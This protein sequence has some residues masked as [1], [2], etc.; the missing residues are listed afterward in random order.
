MSN[1]LLPLVRFC[2][3]AILNMLPTSF[4]SVHEVSAFLSPIVGEKGQSRPPQLVAS[5]NSILWVAG[6]SAVP[7]R[8]VD[9]RGCQ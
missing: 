3:S 9:I 1:P 8:I 6:S 5:C 4:E 7:F 2:H